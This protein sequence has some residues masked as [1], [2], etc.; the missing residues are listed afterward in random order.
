M[1]QFSFQL[2]RSGQ[3][4]AG[5]L[6]TPHATVETPC[7]MPV[8]S[9]ATVKTLTPDEIKDLGYLL[10]LANNYHLYLRP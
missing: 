2:E 8:G 6:T 3:Y 9:Q 10:I 4:R 7:F 1:N 5:L